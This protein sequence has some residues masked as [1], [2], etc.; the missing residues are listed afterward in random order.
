MHSPSVVT[1]LTTRFR[2][3][4]DAAVRNDILASL[5]RLYHREAE[6]TSGWWGTRPNFA[7]PYFAPVTWEGSAS[8]RPV[9]R[10]V[11]LAGGAPEAF[12]ATIA[13]LIRNRV[14]PVGARA[15]VTDV[16][17][18]KH[19]RAAELV[20]ALLGSQT[21][22]A[23]AAPLL[24][25]L[26]STATL[27]PGVAQLLAGENSVGN[28]FVPLLR[29]A[30][31][32]TRL[33]ADVRAQLLG[34]AGRLPGRPGLE[35][36]VDLF[37]RVNADSGTA[38][39]IDMAW[40]R[41]VGDR[42]RQ[43][44]LDYFIELSR[45]DDADRRTLGFSVLL[46]LVRGNRVSQNVRA[47]VAPVIDSTW[48]ERA[49][50][51][52]L[53]RAITIMR[54][55]SQYQERLDVY[56]RGGGETTTA[57]AASGPPAAQAPVQRLEIP[58]SAW[59][60]LFNGRDLSNWDI[61]FTGHPLGTN[62]NDTFRVEN[63]MLTVRYDK[64]TG[65]NGEFGHIFTKQSFSHYVVAA[66]YRFVGEQVA[67]AG[68]GNAWAIRN[69][70]LMLH[71]QSASSMGEKQDFPISLEL[72]LLG[73]L[74][75]G[76][77]TTGNLCTPG[78]HV[79]RNDRLVTTHCMNSTSQTYDGDVWVRIEALVLGDSIIKHIVNGDTVFTF[80]KPQMGGGSANNTNPGV[81]VAG[82]PLTEGHIALQAET[83]PIEFRKVEIVNLVG[84][85]D[86]ASP[87]YRSYFVKGDPAACRQ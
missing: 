13:E 74:G 60:P 26:D 68:Q 19:A 16:V 4:T 73:G 67:G 58:A 9:L 42:R 18:S 82:K 3:S 51:A 66:E 44:E 23:T 22:A 20:D 54:V 5:A 55:E 15:I 69:N 71:S 50:A 27:R 62:L 30:A 72:Q 25:S 33:D 41:F 48:N 6:W 11:L 59:V 14:L 35:V 24:A 17:S 85:M 1:E 40:R 47:R 45:A 8:V 75:R 37:A 38:E 39:P 29:S 57:S 86:R 79:V 49:R 34:L 52:Q 53:V 63:G 61:K 12:D 32:D 7:G 81:L 21:V 78:T 65:F 28:E 84:C 80:S 46:Q 36:A 43:Q 31:T 2:R 76:P 87:R 77:R 70:G 64:W 83:H 56:R 10:E